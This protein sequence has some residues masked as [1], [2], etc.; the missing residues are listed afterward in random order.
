[1][2]LAL[3][4]REFGDPVVC[5]KG[6]ILEDNWYLVKVDQLLVANDVLNDLL[7]LREMLVEDL[8]DAQSRKD[9]EDNEFVILMQHQELH[10]DVLWLE[11][12]VGEEPLISNIEANLVHVVW[13]DLV[14]LW[15]QKLKDGVK[16]V[17]HKR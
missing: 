2:F 3:I 10:Y 13:L 1:M 5:Q 4:L 9:G 15:V 12:N 7:N 14:C 17:N 16:R 6:Q 11:S 8:L